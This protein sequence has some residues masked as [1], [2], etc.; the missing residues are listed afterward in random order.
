MK[1]AW[2]KLYEKLYGYRYAVLVLLAGVL[3]LLLPTRAEQAEN[4]EEPLL[5][6]SEDEWL[7]GVERQLAETLSHIEGAGALHLM[8][9][10]EQGME[11]R[12]RE[13]AEIEEGEHTETRRYKTVVLTAGDRSE[14]PVLETQ[15]YP[16]FRGAVVV[17]EGGDDAAVRLK[18]MEAVRV[19]TGLNSDKIT[20]VK[21]N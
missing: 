19:L 10:V 4:E 12:Y 17:C 5:T 13:D 1:Q 15:A 20:V 21:G 2:A 18:I 16:I 9:S 7:R 8:I 3:L 11:K 14:S 6:D